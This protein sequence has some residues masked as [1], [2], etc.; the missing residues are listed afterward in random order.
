MQS[1]LIW[2]MAGLALA[3]ATV[4]SAAP[5]ATA[6]SARP[7]AVKADYRVS[8]AGVDIGR[9]GFRS[10]ATGRGYTASASAK[11]RLLLGA[12]KWTGSMSGSGRSSGGEVVPA[13]YSQ[14]FVSKRKLLFKTK[15]KSKSANLKFSGRRI[16][17]ADVSPPLKTKDRVPL[18]ASHKRG[19]LDPLGA[20]VSLTTPAAGRNP[21]A[22]RVPIFDG[23]QRFDLK[24][25]PKSRRRSKGGTDH[26]CS[27]R[28]IPIAGHRIN[29]KESQDIARRRS[30]EVTLR[31]V[32]GSAILIPTRVRVPTRAGTAE[33]T[34]KQ[35]DI[36]TAAAKRIRLTN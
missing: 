25:A 11:V 9:F 18:R 2:T 10:E 30:V 26:I 24:L 8:F 28:Y 19:V 15:R 1:K 5:L 16:V 32:D 22:R 23:R 13:R 3:V 34:L 27:V 4:V 20:L 31:A 35:V 7:A 14:S 21:C 17:S 29:G 33:L 12:L 6:N 36:T